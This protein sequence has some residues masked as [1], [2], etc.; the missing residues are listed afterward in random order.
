MQQSNLETLR[1][2]AAHLLAN[3]VKEIYKDKVQVTIGPVIENGFYYDFATDLKFSTEDFAKIEKKMHEISVRNTEIKRKILTKEQ[4][5]KYFESIGEKYKVQIINSI[6]NSEELSIYSQGSFTDLCRGPHVQ[7]TG[8]IKFFKLLKVSGAYWRGDSKNEMLQRIYGT[9]FETQDAL[10]EYLVMLDEIEKRDHRK[11]G[12]KLDLFRQ[13]SDY[14]PGDVFWLPKGLILYNLVKDVVI[15]AIKADYIEVKTPEI[16]ARKLWEL[17]GHW[18]KYKKNMFTSR[19]DEEDMD[20]AVKPMNCPCHV[21]IFKSDVRSYKDLPMRI[22]EFGR[23]HRFEPSGSLHGLMRV[24][25]FTI[26]D[27]HIFCTENQ[28]LEETKK[29]YNLF[30]SVYEK[31]DLAKDIKIK[32]ATRPKE[33]AG[34]DET[35]NKAESSLEKALNDL[36][37]PFE[38][39]P[40]DGAFYGPKLEF[41]LKDCIGRTWTCGTFQLD[42][43]LPERLSAFYINENGEKQHPVMLHRAI[44][45]SLERFIGILIENYKGEFPFWLAPIQIVTLGVSNKF[46]ESVV[47]LTNILS[48][49]FKAK[50]GQDLRITTDIKNERVGY[51]VRHWTEQ[52]IPYIIT[53]GEKEVESNFEKLAIRNLKA[54]TEV[55]SADEFVDKLITL[56]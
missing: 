48:A 14:S 24:R 23:C 30:K 19:I 21:E 49:K 38:F 54:E 39:A 4:A 10:D 44:V 5:I 31:F 13:F 17:S 27:A 2:S 1:H 55:L 56:L 41:H 22:A 25:A 28:I 12:Q 32:L 51:K 3:A 40:E 26:D 6:S 47:N 52:K 29:F 18:D 33:K 9:A 8:Q 7:S 15:N 43:V 37:I 34:S 20:F 46:D 11:L 50:S 36:N 53:I 16:V 45:G 42:F 35:W